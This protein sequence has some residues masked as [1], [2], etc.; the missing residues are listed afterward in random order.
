MSSMLQNVRVRM[1]G[2]FLGA[3]K[4]FQSALVKKELPGS[5]LTRIAD[6][7]ITRLNTIAARCTLSSR[8]HLRTL[9][10]EILCPDRSASPDS[11]TRTTARLRR[12]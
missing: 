1:R 5:S 2:N 3:G 10:H 7:S 9:L 8:Q 12:I 4:A 6:T 11:S